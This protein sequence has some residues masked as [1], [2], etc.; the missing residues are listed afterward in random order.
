MLVAG[1]P[2]LELCYR[3]L[4]NFYLDWQEIRPGITEFRDLTGDEMEIAGLCS[5]VAEQLRF[6]KEIYALAKERG[7]FEYTHCFSALGH[8]IRIG[9]KDNAKT[10][11]EWE[12][13]ERSHAQD[14]ES[15]LE[16]KAKEDLE[17]LFRVCWSFDCPICGGHETL[18]A[19]IDEAAMNDRQVLTDRCSCVHCGF[20]VGRGAEY[21]S[22]VLLA[23]QISNGRLGI[24]KE[25]GFS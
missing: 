4:F 11:I 22:Q 3:T 18:V 24:L 13:S 19:E 20:R 2:F 8:F 12:I 14:A 16:R 7:D 1:L 23:P 6:V 17:D 9:L 15:E 10:E 25:Y 5:A 21:I